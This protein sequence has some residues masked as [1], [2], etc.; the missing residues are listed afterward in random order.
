MSEMPNENHRCKGIAQE[1]ENLPTV[2][3]SCEL[4]MTSYKVFTFSENST[5]MIL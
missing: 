2:I 1:M 4:K 3:K 5:Q